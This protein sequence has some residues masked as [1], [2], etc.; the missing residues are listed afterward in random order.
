MKILYAKFVNFKGIYNGTGRTEVELDFSKSDNKITLLAGKNG[1]GKSTILSLLHPFAG[2]LDSRAN[3]IIRDTVGY[4]EVIIADG[5]EQYLIKHHYDQTKKRATTKSYFAKKD[6]TGVWEELNENGTVKSFEDLVKQHLDVDTSF[7]T[8][9]RIGSNVEGFIDKT[10]TERKKYISNFL[11]SIDEYL[12][13][14]K[15]VSEQWTDLNK[16]IK[17]VVESINKL[18]SIDHILATLENLNNRLDQLRQSERGYSSIVSRSEGFINAKD[19][20]GELLDEYNNV[21]KNFKIANEEYKEIKATLEDSKYSTKEEAE[22]AEVEIGKL[23]NEANVELSKLE[24][25]YTSMKNART[26][27]YETIERDKD[28]LE[29]IS[30]PITIDEYKKITEQRQNDIK[31]A[32]SYLEELSHLKDLDI[33]N[34]NIPRFET[35]MNN[36]VEY[37]EAVVD[38]YSRPEIEATLK[39]SRSSKDVQSEIE[40]IDNAIKELEDTIKEVDDARKFHIS[41]SNLTGILEQKPSDCVNYS[42]AFIAEAVKYKDSPDKVDRLDKKLTKLNEQKKQKQEE[43]AQLKRLYKLLSSIGVIIKTFKRTENDITTLKPDFSLKNRQEVVDFIFQD[44]SFITSTSDMRQV[45][46]NRSIIESSIDEIKRANDMIKKLSSEEE[47]VAKL[48]DSIYSNSKKLEKLE[49]DIV[50]I[51]EDIDEWTYDKN[52]YRNTLVDLAKIIPLFTD[53][54]KVRNVIKDSKLKYDDMKKDIEEIREKKDAIKEAEDKIDEITEQIEP[55]ESD[56]NKLKLNIERLKEYNNDKAELEDKLKIVTAIRDSLSP[57]KGIPLLFI[58]VYLEQTKL[59]ANEL[60]DIA[61]NGTFNIDDFIINEKEFRIR[62]NKEGGHIDD[63]SDITDCSQGER[64]LTSVALSMALIKQSLKRYNILCLDEID[65]ELD[66][67]NRRAFL[68]IIDSL[69]D[70]LG[71]EQ[72]FI[73]THNREFDTAPVDL[74]IMPGADIDI[75]D[76]EFMKGKHIIGQY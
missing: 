10:P 32:N 41:K 37:V 36:L 29:S 73:I 75:E 70:E 54:E 65:S 61:Y 25:D 7:F 13:L 8:L 2:T 42:C 68:S 44:K 55:L 5:D 40:A 35:A 1:S 3:F 74:V 52:R 34:E 56:I 20:N 28:T 15:R 14:Y 51:K 6:I 63:D 24:A 33:T 9:S 23:L 11:P 69:M 62:M 31:E 67:D 12:V 21:L 18:D 71:I 47:L 16:R 46:I 27:L 50:E 59:I 43:L 76:K 72:T 57:T 48:K 49:S 26:T 64:A 38:D 53:L 60:I 58:D 39:D 66:A 30:D 17:N 19:P 4:K 45:I 22:K